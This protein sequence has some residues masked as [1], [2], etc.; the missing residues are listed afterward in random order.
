MFVDDGLL[1]EVGNSAKKLRKLRIREMNGTKLSDTG[2]GDVFD[3]CWLLEELEL[4]AVEG[5]CSR[6]ARSG[7]SD[8]HRIV[9]LRDS[10]A[11]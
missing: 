10:I 5:E 7:K 11:I 6:R 9:L 4:E 1:A 2:L 8:Y 3:G